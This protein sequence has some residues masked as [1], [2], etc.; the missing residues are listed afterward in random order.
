MTIKPKR[1]SRHITLSKE[2]LAV[3]DNWKINGEANKVNQAI[4]EYDNKE[5][6]TEEQK[7]WIMDRITE[8]VHT[9]YK[10]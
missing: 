6:F 3:Y 8:A 10:P 4:I 1:D 7:K 5:V 2:A 9:C